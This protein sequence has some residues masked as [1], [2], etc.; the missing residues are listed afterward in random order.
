MMN[1]GMK[2]TKRC[3]S[4]TKEVGCLTQDWNVAIAKINYLHGMKWIIK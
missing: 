3:V 4:E 1:S 2:S